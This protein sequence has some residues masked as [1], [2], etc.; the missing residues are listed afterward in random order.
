MSRGVRYQMPAAGRKVLRELT[1]KLE[2]EREKRGLK[3][4]PFAK[5]IGL[6]AQTYLDWCA[7]KGNPTLSTLAYVFVKLEWDLTAFILRAE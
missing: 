7:G 6:S 2:V 5:L 1:V 3:K 4:T